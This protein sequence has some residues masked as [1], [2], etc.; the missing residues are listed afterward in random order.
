M[1]VS[2]TKLAP[3]LAVVLC[4]LGAAPAAADDARGRTLFEL[5][6]QCHGAA[7]GGNAAIEAPA[8]A[9]LPA[10][11]VESQLVKFKGGVRAYHA[12]D[13]GGLRMRPMAMWLKTDEDIAAVAAYV[14]S[15]PA[16]RPAP[17]LPIA[18][19]ARGEQLYA[20]CTACHGPDAGGNPQLFAPPL[21]AASDWYLL[22]QLR[23]F[24]SGVRG[25][26]PEDQ[27]GALMR[28]MAMTLPDEQAMKDV[29]AYILTRSK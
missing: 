4:A 2:L 6:T 1:A 21:N 12:A 29:V 7:G 23:K 14:A 18:D 27:T 15:L 9:A 25:A 16:A 17:T 8:I 19:T 20:P 10:W 24:K 3:A 11:Y 28:P 22:A 5:C 26:H 13:A